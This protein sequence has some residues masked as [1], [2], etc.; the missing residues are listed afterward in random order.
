MERHDQTHVSE[1]GRRRGG[2]CAARV[3]IAARPPKRTQQRRASG[4]TSS[5]PCRPAAG[6]RS[7]RRASRC[8][9][10]RFSTKRRPAGF[11]GVRLTGFPGLLEQNG[12]TRRAIWRRAGQP[13]AAVLDRLVWR[14]LLRLAAARRHP[15]AGPRGAGGAPASSA[16]RRWSFFRRRRC[17]Q[18]EEAEALDAMFAFLDELGK[19]AVEEY[20]IRMGLHNHTDTLV[21]N[22]RQ[23]DR[24]LEGTDPRYVFCRLGLGPPAG[25]RMRRAGDLQE[26]DRSARLHRL[27]G[28][29]APADGRRLPGPQRHALRRRLRTRGGSTTR[30]SSWAAARST[31]CR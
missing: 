6:D 1:G 25:G 2:R 23:V 20:G 22:Q 4:P 29:H 27:Q 10:C 16:P 3:A 12:L 15:P 18:A 17:R 26:V 11:N 5:M 24:F 31:S 21:E 8:R 14:Q 13:R 7:R 9:C 28:R 30:C 19:M